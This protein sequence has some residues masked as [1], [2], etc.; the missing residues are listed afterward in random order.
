MK[1]ALLTTSLMRGGAE[2]QVF[3]L[4]RTLK[5]RGHEV[6]VISMVAPEAFEPELVELG[7]PLHS[8]NMRPG[9]P[10]PRALWRLTAI[11]RAW[12][13][14][15]LHSHMI[16]ANLLGRLV[17]LIVRVPVQI[18]TAHNI[19]EGGRWRERAYRLTDPLATITTNVSQAAVDRYVQ[20]GAV[21][22]AK[23][24]YL[25]N[26]LELT[27]FMSVSASRQSLR[28]ALGLTEQFV[29]L[30]VGRLDVQKDY[31]TMLRALA[32]TLPGYPQTRLLI[33]S[34]GPLRADLEALSAQLS[35]AEQVTFLG[36]RNDV[37]ALMQAADAYL[38]SSAWEGLPMVLLEAAASSLPIVATDVGGNREIVLDGKSGWL[39]PPSDPVALAA[40][41]Q[42]LMAMPETARRQMGEAGRN[43]VRQHYDLERVVD[44][45]EALYQE[46][47]SRYRGSR[48]QGPITARRS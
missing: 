28:Q 7:I 27:P 1:I 43:Y 15:I 9:A 26:G 4:A 32:A 5:R 42:R 33:V 24:R 40:A 25:P 34:E 8:L 46:L 19:D 48:R 36:A 37:P 45:W 20:V 10:D 41:M 14:E 6:Q 18:S 30:A 17:R 38:M 47:L 16:H 2:I 21:P 44:T 3:L 31:P 39:V 29:W 35:L 11:L 22:A 23:I 13:P 12:R